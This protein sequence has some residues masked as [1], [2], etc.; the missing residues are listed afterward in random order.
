MLETCR[1]KKPRDK[2]PV[3]GGVMKIYNAVYAALHD[4]MFHDI[5]SMNG[6]ILE[7][8]DD[9]NSKPSRGFLISDATTSRNVEIVKKFIVSTLHLTFL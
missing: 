3:E 2:G 8:L 6:R 5:D 4:E 1:I 9:F 7:L